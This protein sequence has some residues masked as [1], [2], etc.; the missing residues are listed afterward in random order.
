MARALRIAFEDALY[1][2]SARG[3]RREQIFVSKDDFARFEHLLAESLERY[4]V[5]LHS[6]VL[7]PNHFHLLA[8]TLK[9]NVSRWMHWLI[10]SYSIWFNRSHQF[11]G[12]VFRGRYK[13]FLVQQ[14]DYLLELGRYLHLNPVRGSALSSGSSEERQTSLR[15]YQWSSYR[16]YAGLSQQ[17]PFVRENLTFDEFSS[18]KA[19]QKNRIQYREFVEEGLRHNI[20]SPF[21]QVRQQI[22]LGDE[23]FARRLT[24]RVKRMHY[25]R[26]EITGF[27]RIKHRPDSSQLIDRV[28]RHY[29]VPRQA[30]TSRG[31]PGSEARNVAIWLLRQKG[32]L[33][34]REIGQVFG[35]IDYAAVS[36]R[37]RRLNQRIGKQKRLRIACKILNA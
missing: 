19:D 2:L 7:L 34:L 32:G 31:G 22:A 10:T 8:R 3:N 5:E 14:G 36:Q 1:H 33:T 20:A 11:V 6:Y 23:T 4:Q 25:S 21:R 37:V 27:R 29:K 13:G 35:G 30:I 18:G 16:G 12:H 15:D 9:P 17:K 28:A 24:E 26:R